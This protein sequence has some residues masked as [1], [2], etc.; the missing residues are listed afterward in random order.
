MVM[1][2]E[3]TG[4]LVKRSVRYDRAKRERAAGPIAF[5]PGQVN[6]VPVAVDVRNP[7]ALSSRIGIGKAARKERAGR[8]RSVQLER[9]CGTLIAHPA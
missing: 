3:N 8:F 7:Q 2:Q 9:L 4:G 1:G 6:A 5:A